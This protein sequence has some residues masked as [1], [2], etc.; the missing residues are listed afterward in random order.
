[1][2]WVIGLLGHRIEE[3][4]LP[5]TGRPVGEFTRLSGAPVG[6]SGDVGREAFPARRVTGPVIGP[7]GGGDMLLWTFGVCELWRRA[8]RVSSR[9][10][11]VSM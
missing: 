3:A 1:M 10:L 9:S 6:K 4:L 11:I 2:Q 5:P 8:L 7:R